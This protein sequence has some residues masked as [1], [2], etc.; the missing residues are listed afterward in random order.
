M[1]STAFLTAAAL[2]AALSGTAAAQTSTAPTVAGETRSGWVASGFAG[3]NFGTTTDN[4]GEVDDVVDLDTDASIDFGGQVAYLWK[5]VF[6]G[7]VLANFAP[8][9][10]SAGVVFSDKPNIYSYMANAIGAYP[11]GAEGKY[12]PYV[13]GGFGAI[14]VLADVFNVI[15]DPLSGTINSNDTKFGGNIGAGIMAFAGHLGIRG[16]IRYF[17]ATTDELPIEPDDSDAAARSALSG[18]GFWRG[19]VGMAF[20]W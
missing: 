11:L 14:Q 9:V 2:S 8:S 10:G 17:K 4:S 5:G 20:R 12:Q 1:R 18:L 13:S 16:D 15:G 7:E 6:G 19:N 3:A